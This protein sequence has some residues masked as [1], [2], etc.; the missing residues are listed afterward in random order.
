MY[1]YQFNLKFISD[2]RQYKTLKTGHQR[3]HN[4]IEIV[5][6]SDN[7]DNNNNYD[8]PL[9]YLACYKNISS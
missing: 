3:T 8:M 1:L 5:V 7:S 6:I 9:N 4:I 2:I